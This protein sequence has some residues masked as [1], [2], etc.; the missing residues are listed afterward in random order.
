MTRKPIHKPTCPL[1]SLLPA[2][3]KW[4]PHCGIPLED[5]VQVHIEPRSIQLL[6]EGFPTVIYFKDHR[7]GKGYRYT[8]RTGV[9]TIYDEGSSAVAWS[10]LDSLHG[11]EISLQEWKLWV[12]PATD[13]RFVVATSVQ[14][15]VTGIPQDIRCPYCLGTGNNFSS[16]WDCCATC[17]GTGMIR[18]PQYVAPEDQV[19]KAS[20]PCSCCQGSGHT[21]EVLNPQG[22]LLDGDDPEV[23]E[24]TCIHCSGSGN[25]PPDGIP[26]DQGHPP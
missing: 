6:L 25:E 24:I 7:T 14:A 21:Q 13:Y 17:D 12:G 2:E 8:L 5:G 18:N 20:E 11:D 16:V 10:S 22:F 4:C 26:Q 1:T 19:V 15:P 3:Y 23:E 9:V